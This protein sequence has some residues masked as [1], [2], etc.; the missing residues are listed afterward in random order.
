MGS[1]KSTCPPVACGNYLANERRSNFL[2]PEAIILCAPTLP[3]ESQTQPRAMGVACVSCKLRDEFT[4]LD[5]LH[6]QGSM[7]LLFPRAT[8]ASLSGVI[9]NTAGG[10][11][12]GDRFDMSAS[13]APGCRMSLTLRRLNGPTGRNRV[14]LRISP[15]GYRLAGRPEWTGCRKKC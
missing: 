5:R 3:C 4:V 15:T 12:G 7:K 8:G 1:P 2:P 11:T 10:V 14:K 6:Q 13:V 9:I